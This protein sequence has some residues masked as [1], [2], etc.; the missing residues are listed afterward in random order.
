[1]LG[2][3]GVV[4]NLSTQGQASGNAKVVTSKTEDATTKYEVSK[5]SLVQRER[6]PI[7]KL[8]TVSVLG[9]TTALK[10]DTGQVPADMKARIESIVTNAIGFVEGRDT[11]NVEFLPFA[12][13]EAVESTPVSAIPW[14]QITEI[15]RNAS[16]A[17]G[18]LVA[19]VVAWLLLGRLKPSP[20]DSSPASSGAGSARLDQLGKLV[21][22]NPEVFSR[23]VA[24]WA[25]STAGSGQT[26]STKDNERKEAA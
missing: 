1:M 10:D 12:E 4:S 11:I 19:F 6:T 26:E 15:L 23:I 18:A 7:L 20:I 2:G 13:L 21:E 16:L 5:T 24:A 9:N 3:A 25:T 14:G 17:V 22:E 8:M